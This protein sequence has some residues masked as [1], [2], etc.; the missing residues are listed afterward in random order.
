MDRAAMDVAAVLAK[1][2]FDCDAENGGIYQLGDKYSLPLPKLQPKSSSPSRCYG[3]LDIVLYHNNADDDQSELPEMIVSQHQDPG[4]LILSLPQSAPGLALQ[5]SNGNW[6]EPPVGQ[7]ILWTGSAAA[8]K[9]RPCP[10]RV[11]TCKGKP[12]LA[13]W[14]VICTSTQISKPMLE[15]LEAEQRELQMG[16]ITGTDQVLDIFRT[17]ENHGVS[18]EGGCH[19]LAI[20]EV[21]FAGVPIFKIEQATFAVFGSKT[22][23]TRNTPSRRISVLV[24][25]M[26]KCRCMEQKKDSSSRLTLEHVSKAVRLLQ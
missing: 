4:L 24:V 14:H 18:S 13:C 20:V 11:R 6:H 23:S 5:D 22:T 21:P 7:G 17:A 26:I 1:P 15:Q 8:G 10:H 3:L 25:C 9:V 19:H 16:N 2:L 12:R